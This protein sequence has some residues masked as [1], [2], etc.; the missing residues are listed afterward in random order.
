[1]VE[2]TG[3][4]L[5]LVPVLHQQFPEARYLHLYRYGP[6]C[7]LSMSRHP[8]FRLPA[9]ARDVARNAG[10]PFLST[11]EIQAAAL[12]L[13]SDLAGLVAPPFDAQ[14]FMTREIPLAFFG[15]LW[16]CLAR[17]GAA[18]LSQLPA[19][20]WIGLKYEELVRDPEA[21]LTK[22]AEF[23][24]V[25]ATPRWL[26][27]GCLIADDQRVGTAASQLSP[28]DL[29]TVQEACAPGIAAIAAV[30]AGRA[31]PAP[32]ALRLTTAGKRPTSRDQAKA[33]AGPDEL[34]RREKGTPCPQPI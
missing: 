15:E 1:V 6:D 9:L 27:A 25:P 24:G 21:E 31:P 30:R 4:S 5:P 28:G 22:L 7:A 3:A 29:A 23:I 34:A 17:E 33:T 20:T 19:G 32:T 13:P 18:A 12:R 8:M 16:S 2:R 11:D 26:A 14:R 10:L